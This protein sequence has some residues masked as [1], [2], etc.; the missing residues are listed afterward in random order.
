MS[1]AGRACFFVTGGLVRFDI[2][3]ETFAGNTH[4]SSGNP[5]QQSRQVSSSSLLAQHGCLPLYC[6]RCGQ[7]VGGRRSDKTLCLF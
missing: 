4:E 2:T 7:R 3:D 5:P 1:G 6:A